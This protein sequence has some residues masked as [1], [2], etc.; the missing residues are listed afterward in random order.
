MKFISD[1]LRDFLFR[2]RIHFLGWFIFIFYE[3]VIM[4]VIRGAFA[5]FGNY[6]LFYLFNILLFYFHAQVVMP[7]AKMKTMQAIWRL[8]LFISIEVLVYIPIVLHTADFLNK[9]GVLTLIEPVQFTFR[10]HTNVAY[11]AVY[12]ILFATGYYYILNYFKERKRAEEKE[13]ERLMVIIE[14][15]RI[16]AD[17]IKSQHAH[18]KAQINP[19]FLFNTLNFIY[20]NTRKTAPEA[21]EAIMALSEIMRYSIEEVKDH[22][23]S[24]LVEELEQVENLIKLHQIKANHGLNIALKYDEEELERI[25]IIPLLV[26]TLAENMFKH[27]ELGQKDCPA[28]IELSFSEGVLNIVTRNRVS[29]HQAHTSHHIGLS[30]VRKRLKSAYGKNARL[31]TFVTEDQ[32]FHAQLVIEL[33]HA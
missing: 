23:Q 16:Y 10:A 18:L 12:F 17:L 31:D 1:N 19:H 15:Q 6:A 33:H 7:A 24:A 27:G 21:A 5:T 8:P 28:T 13:K 14:N 25:Q 30:N 32:Y 2:Y 3:V 22:A 4:G 9:N 20:T 26:M 29:L 11:R